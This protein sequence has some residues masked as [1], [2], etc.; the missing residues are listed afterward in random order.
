MSRGAGELLACIKRERNLAMLYITHDIATAARIAEEVVV[1]F[2]G[3]MVEWGETN[4]ISAIPAIPVPS[5]SFGRPRSRSS[6]RAGAERPLSGAGPRGAAL[7]PPGIGRGGRGRRKPFCPCPWPGS[8][9]SYLNRGQ[10][11]LRNPDGRS[12]AEINFRGAI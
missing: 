5:F 4:A 12:A 10:S 2:A 3:Q 6:V 9:V 11:C 8:D 1:I 7:E